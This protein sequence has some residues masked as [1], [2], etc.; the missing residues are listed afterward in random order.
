MRIELSQ[1]SDRVLQLLSRRPERCN[2]GW[3]V[4]KD[5]GRRVEPARCHIV[6]HAGGVVACDTA[7]RGKS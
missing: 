4:M 1:D 6:P 5:L 3:E 2:A 7:G